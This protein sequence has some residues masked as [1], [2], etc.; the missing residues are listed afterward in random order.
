MNKNIFLVCTMLLAFIGCRDVVAPEVNNLPSGPFVVWFNGL[1]GNADGYFINDD[2]L[3]TNCWTCGEA[4]NQIIEYSAGV[5]AILSSM[6]S[7]IN[8][9]SGIDH[10]S[11]A[12]PSGSNPYSFGIKGDTGYATL[13]LSSEI[14]VFDIPSMEVTEIFSVESNPS[15]ITFVSDKLFVGYGSYPESSS[16]G[17]V[18]VISPNNGEEIKWLDTGI[19]THWLKTQP[20]GNVHAY[21]TT[22]QNDGAISIINGESMEIETVI[23]CGGAPGEAIGIND[24]F[25]SPDGWGEGGLIK[26][27]ESGNYS[28][29]SLPF[30]PTN[31]TLYGEH[32]YVTSFSSD[33]V[34]I[35]NSTTYQ[36]LDSLQAGGQGPQGVI[37][38]EPVN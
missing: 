24:Y 2:S 4:P 1:S 10:S 17:G 5:F 15:G 38:V 14:A 27:Y 34:Y 33:K 18:S 31:L 22:Y 29:I 13:L 32:L 23:N 36:V 30:A 8:F 16:P 19:N 11:L 3:I 25:L 35:L 21:S 28:R 20:T 7:E 6:S 12:L 26:Y 37:A 9:Y